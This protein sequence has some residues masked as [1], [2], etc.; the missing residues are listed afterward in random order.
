VQAI[1][2]TKRISCGT[3]DYIIQIKNI[4]LEYI[5]AKDIA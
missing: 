5:E 4:P 2:E 3:S 1:N